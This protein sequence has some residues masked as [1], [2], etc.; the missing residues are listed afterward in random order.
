[1]DRFVAHANIR[2][3]KQLLEKERD[4][5]ERRVIERLLKEEE[6]KLGCGE[7]P[8]PPG[9]GDAAKRPRPDLR[10]GEDPA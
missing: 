7:D 8:A 5:A 1:M 3:F 2:R 6:A 4:P 10:T 9:P